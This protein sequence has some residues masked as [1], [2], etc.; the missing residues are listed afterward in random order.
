M[1]SHILTRMSRAAVT[2]TTTYTLFED[3]SLA[4]SSIAL[5]ETACRSKRRRV[6]NTVPHRRRLFVVYMRLCGCLRM[7]REWFYQARLKDVN[8]HP[9]NWPDGFISLV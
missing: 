3:K 2:A 6:H 5:T 8:V 7:D 9:N 4:M 1:H